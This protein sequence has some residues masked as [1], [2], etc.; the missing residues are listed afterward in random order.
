MHNVATFG[1]NLKRKRRALQ[2]NQ[3]QLA[4]LC[5]I[6]QAQISKYEIDKRLP[7]ADSLIALAKGL[8]CSVD[9]LLGGMDPEYDQARQNR[10]QTH[11]D[12]RP[13][14]HSSAALESNGDAQHAAH[15]QVLQNVLIATHILDLS[16]KLKELGGALAQGQG[17]DLGNDVPEFRQSPR[18]DDRREVRRDRRRK[19]AS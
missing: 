18:A 14:S 10:A 1:D 12:Q 19:H 7:S 2:L 3:T 17:A 15:A 4:A 6:A 5:N 11:P 9:D 8:D 16:D 13:A